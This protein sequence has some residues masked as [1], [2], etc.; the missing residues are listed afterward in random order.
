[1]KKPDYISLSN[2]NYNLP[3]HLIA[4][5]PLKQ[6]DESKL[7]VL[8]NNT[9]SQS[10]FKN[11]SHYLP[12][13]SLLLLNNTKVIHARLI[14]KKDSG[15]NIEIFCIEPYLPNNY[16]DS[17]SQSYTNQWICLVGNSKK[18]KDGLLSINKSFNGNDLTIKAER[19]NKHENYSIIKFEWT[20]GY[21]FSEIITYFG[22][23][24]IPP[25]LNRESEN[26]DIERYQTVVSK[27]SGSVAAPTASLHFTEKLLTSLK[28][29][30]FSIEELTL[31]VGAGTFK[32]VSDNNMVNHNMHP[33]HFV[34][35]ISLLT[36]LLNL[37]SPIIPVGTTSVRTIESLKG[38]ALQIINNN[39]NYVDSFSINQW[40]LYNT[41]SMN[42]ATICKVIIEYMNKYNIKE[43]N[44]ITSLMIVP[45][46][47]FNFCDG[48][49]TNFH[50][51]KSTLLLLVSALIGDKW[52]EVY[53]YALNNNFRFLSYGDS[54]L[55]IPIKN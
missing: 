11:I 47:N 15:A 3:D 2:Y 5:Y 31:H 27:N 42:K 32:P 14:F 36:K 49:I 8:S 50:Q 38:I 55:F 4:K 35:N 18:W 7:L 16:V 25:Y 39:S 20:E 33:E 26:I 40:D 44:A 12:I 9:I 22:I 45:G 37:S 10:Y 21:S 28:H 30:G 19:L 48:I 1:M 29:D 13:N 53:D 41:E 52:K 43:I 6:R 54:C 24:P 23:I 46:F 51:P 17:F 34:V